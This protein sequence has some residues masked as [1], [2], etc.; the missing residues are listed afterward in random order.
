MCGRSCNAVPGHVLQS[1]C[2]RQQPPTKGG[3]GATSG[4]YRV[5]PNNDAGT[6]GSGSPYTDGGAG[7]SKNGAPVQWAYP[8]DA[9]R[10]RPRHNIAPTTE[11]PVMYRGEG[12]G[13]ERTLALMHWGL[14]PSWHR[15]TLKDLKLN[16]IN[17]R[18]DTIL[19]KVVCSLLRFLRASA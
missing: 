10:W 14:V 3:N 18:S 9:D 4:S 7:S 16:M 8:T 12:A 1:A 11:I 17:A 15:G 5:P 6:S 19:D 13:G 2:T